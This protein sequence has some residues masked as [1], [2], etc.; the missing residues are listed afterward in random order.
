[1]ASSILTL[2]EPGD[3]EVS[4]YILVPGPVQGRET[5]HGSNE[6]ILVGQVRPAAE[7]ADFPLAS[8]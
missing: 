6:V 1:M 4:L 2:H 3:N 7:S 8:A 5:A